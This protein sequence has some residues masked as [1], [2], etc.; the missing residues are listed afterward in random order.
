MFAWGSG[1]LRGSGSTII[2][3]YGLWNCQ[4]DQQINNAYGGGSVV[5]NNYGTLRK[6]GGAGEFVNNTIFEN[7]V[8]FNQL[9]GVIDV[10]NSTNGLQL[11]FLGGGSLLGGYVTTNSQGLFNL[12]GGNFN[13]NGL[14]TG[15]N[16][17]LNGANLAGTNVIQGALSWYAGTGILLISSPLP[18]IAR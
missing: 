9:S 18:P 4:S 2:N 5:F 1:T 8:I 13:L 16:T 12:A 15:T 11:A 7:G 10:Q 17:W 3:N 6:S 14:V